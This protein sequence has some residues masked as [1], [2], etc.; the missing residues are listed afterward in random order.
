MCS[1]DDR[2]TSVNPSQ[3]SAGTRAHA[4]G[5]RITAD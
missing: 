5:L 2:R 4:A 3:H 1:Y